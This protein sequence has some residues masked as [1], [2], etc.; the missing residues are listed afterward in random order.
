MSFLSRDVYD[1]RR[2]KLDAMMDEGGL[3]GVVVFGVDFFQFLTNFHVDVHAWERPIALIV[4]RSGEPVAVM[5][6]LSTNHLGFANKRGSFWTNVVHFYCEFPL[7]EGDPRSRKT[8][9]EHVVEQIDAAGLGN[10]TVGVDTNAAW[11]E[12]IMAGHAGVKVK[13]TMDGFRKLRWIK[14]AEELKIME[15]LCDL[16]DWTQELYREGIRPGR[17]VHE[18][19]YSIAAK[20]FTE[21]AERF[22]G[23][24]FEYRFFTLS[25]ASS[26]S[27]HGDS[28]QA[29]A[30]IQKG[31]GLINILIP[32]LNGVTIENE[33]TYFVGQ[34]TDLQHRAYDAALEANLASIEQM[35]AGNPVS[36]ID[37][38]PRKI[39]AKHGF[40]QNVV[41]RTGHGMGLINHEFPEDMPFCHRPLIKNEVYSAEPGIYIEGLGGFRAD[42]TVVVGEKSATVLTRSS[43]DFES[44]IIHC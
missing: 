5:N 32:R 12:K 25:G 3:D 29:G 19:D 27:C 22:P 15:Q 1:Y 6:T 16:S 14:H 41:H 9:E 24:N 28:Q 42:D 21:A 4:P 26:A 31:D 35:V 43:K 40:S 30:R 17:L 33:R 36:A 37:E 10:A 18:L 20:V 7:E 8:F 11:L 38:A 13:S 34:P 2:A 23:E 44:R 39:F